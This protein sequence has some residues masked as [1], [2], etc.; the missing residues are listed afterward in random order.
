LKTEIKIV[1]GSDDLT[2]MQL[3]EM[4]ISKVEA[5]NLGFCKSK[6]AILDFKAIKF[7]GQ[8]VSKE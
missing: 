1:F 5:S 3:L 8:R 7:K 6:V 4:I 2:P